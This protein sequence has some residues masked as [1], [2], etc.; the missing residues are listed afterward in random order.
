MAR[1]IAAALA[2]ALSACAGAAPVLD[3]PPP[4]QRGVSLGLFSP[5]EEVDYPQRLAEIRALGATHVSLVITWVQNDVT[6]SDVRASP[7]YTVSEA[8]LRRLVREAHACGMQVLIFPIL[9]LEHRT[10][11]EWRG[12]IRPTD[13]PHWFESYGALLV[14]LARLAAEE[15]VEV[16][17]VGSELASTEQRLDEWTRLIAR[18]RAAYRGS[19]L[20]SANWDHYDR[21]PFWPLVDQIGVSAYWGVI[22]PGHAPTLEE[23]EAAWGPIRTRLAAFARRLGRPVVLTEVG[24]Q[25]VRGAGAFPWN[26][27]L[28]GA[29]GA[30]D[31]EAQRVLYEAF[32]RGWQDEPELAGVYFWIWF[33]AGGPSDRGYTPRGKPAELVLRSWYRA[34]ERLPPPR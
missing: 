22:A 20:Y 10:A 9:R 24:Y 34:P 13:L 5:P 19:L 30:L 15:H 17:S 1:L 7:D 18:V 33:D 28:T 4:F 23:A 8:L 11:A 32:A 3:R 25:S 2:C 29:D 6:A 16:L 14:E 12:S 31:D 21:V 27:F 26:D